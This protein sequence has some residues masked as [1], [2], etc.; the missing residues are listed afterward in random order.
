[1]EVVVADKVVQVGLEV[2]VVG[3]VLSSE[4]YF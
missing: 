1:V 3:E 2:E 4:I